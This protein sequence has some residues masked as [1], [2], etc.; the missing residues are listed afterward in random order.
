MLI[1]KTIVT[2]HYV[3]KSPIINDV[4]INKKHFAVIEHNK[5]FNQ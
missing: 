4:K 1:Q 3:Q 5:D 2:H